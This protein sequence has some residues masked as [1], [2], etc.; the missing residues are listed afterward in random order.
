L[1]LNAFV[2][3]I[4]AAIIVD[5]S[6]GLL[7]DILNL[8]A[9]RF[10]VPQSLR[11]IYNQEDYKRSQEYSRVTIIFGIISRTVLQIVVLIFWF[12]GGFGAIDRLVRSPGLPT[13][14]EGLL[15]IGILLLG[16]TLLEL[17]FSVYR[18]FR[19]ETRFGFNRTTRL[20]FVTDH[21]KGLALAMVLGI[22]LVSGILA[23]FEY[24]GQY[25]WLF[26]WAGVTLY[27]LVVQF[28]APVWIMP[29]FNKFTPMA[30]GD[31]KEAILGYADSVKFPVTNVFVMDGS[32]RSSRSNAYFTG[33]GR[34]KRIALFD[35]LIKQHTAQEIVAVL[36]HEVGHYK[37]KHIVKNLIVSVAHTGLL[38]FLLSVFIKS[39]GLY[40]AFHTEQSVYAGL[41]FFSL[42]YTPVELVVSMITN[43]MSRSY[44]R[45]ADRFAATT[46][47]E[48]N[49][50]TEALKKLSK[51][52]LSNLT[53][54]PF[55]V[56]VN[57]SH[58][59]LLQRI[60]TIKGITKD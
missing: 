60:R 1:T 22:P 17:P 33:F 37:K 32:R 2:L 47:K 59:T 44:E 27:S 9:L 31:L 20:T 14:I 43:A 7:A 54:H 48:P 38:F 11:D 50:F 42:L 6:V 13:I 52:N 5:Y 57:Y 21:L 12:A 34:N 23:L 16:Y 40:E 35:T 45:E 49:T 4:F 25:A 30:D 3:I 18:T 39:P 53:P 56:F 29:L 28:A 55:Y 24:G 36:A 26:V 15:F 58:P 51:N 19:I 41:V 10:E 46:I 8:K